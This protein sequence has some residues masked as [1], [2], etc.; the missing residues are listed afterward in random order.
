MKVLVDLRGVRDAF[1]AAPALFLR[2]SARGAKEGLT[3]WKRDARQQHNFTSRSGNLARAIQVDFNNWQGQGLF[4][5]SGSAA[6]GGWVHDGTRPHKIAPRFKKA[7]YFIK[8]G[9]RVIVLKAGWKPPH[10]IAGWMVRAGLIG[11]DRRKASSNTIWS[12]K[13]Y[14]DHPGTKPDPF[15]FQAAERGME[16]LISKISEGIGR[17]IVK[18]GLRRAR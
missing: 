12:H 16:L 7:L 8:G 9:F 15:I 14:V 18:L 5:D 17:A 1:L 3:E 11:G 4:N 2:E 6:Y 10:A 13:G